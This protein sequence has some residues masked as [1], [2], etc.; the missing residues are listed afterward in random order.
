M[1][2]NT[3]FRPPV[4]STTLPS[5][6][7]SGNVVTSSRYCTSISNSFLNQFSN[8]DA[9][10]SP[11]RVPD[12]THTKSKPSFNFTAF[13]L[14]YL[15]FSFQN[16]YLF[17]PMRTYYQKSN[18]ESTVF[19]SITHRHPRRANRAQQAHKQIPIFRTRRPA[20]VSTSHTTN[21][22]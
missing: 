4:F 12:H 7:R 9:C 11:I 6:S 8:S 2:K 15:S 13:I 14:Y 5:L 17:Q 22:P 21:N 20:Q 1:A 10:F 3:S 16:W 18:F 19:L